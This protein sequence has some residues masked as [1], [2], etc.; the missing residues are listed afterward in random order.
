MI[1]SE[2]ILELNPV[3]HLLPFYRRGEM[4]KWHPNTRIAVPEE[5]NDN[6]F[7]PSWEER[8]LQKGLHSKWIPVLGIAAIVVILLF[9][10][11]LG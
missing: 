5:N 11:L 6:D 8:G 4:A 7:K 9:V 2:V 1:S 10:S 3:S